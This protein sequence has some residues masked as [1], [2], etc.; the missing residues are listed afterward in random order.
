MLRS[1]CAVLIAVILGLTLA[2]FIEGMGSAALGLDP[3]PGPM[4]D[5]RS[6][7]TQLSS[8]MAGV[9]LA[10]WWISAFVASCTSLLIGGRWA[11]LAWLAATCISFNAIISL[12]AVAAPWWIWPG[13]VASAAIGGY[14]GIRAF[15]GTYAVRRASRKTGVF[16]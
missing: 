1:L 6:G 2:R 3:G 5:D 7:K 9:L 12:L 16:E 14:L 8:G 11:P 15:G 4:T 13:G 10:S